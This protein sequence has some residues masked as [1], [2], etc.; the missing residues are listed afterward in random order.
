MPIEE[1]A[2]PASG[3][4]LRQRVEAALETIRPAI[5]GDGGDIELVDVTDDGLVKVRF[6]G[7]CVGCMASAMTL[8][9]GVERTLK[10]HVP[11]VKHV[12]MA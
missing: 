11:E 3:K 1:R 7:A 4:S 12:V 5:Q 8:A 10:L 9:F 2:G 6:R